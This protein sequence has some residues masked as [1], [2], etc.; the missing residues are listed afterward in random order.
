MSSLLQ[1]RLQS[2]GTISLVH[3]DQPMQRIHN[4]MVHIERSWDRARGQPCEYTLGDKYPRNV[5]GTANSIFPE[6]IR[7][8]RTNLICMIISVHTG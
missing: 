3:K 2:I 8:L 4:N 7:N 6:N 5:M 1:F